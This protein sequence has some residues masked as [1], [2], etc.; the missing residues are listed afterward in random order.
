M[1]VFRIT[2]YVDIDTGKREAT[3]DDAVYVTKT[4]LEELVEI[5][6]LD[7]VV[8]TDYRVDQAEDI[9]TPSLL[10]MGSFDA[11]GSPVEK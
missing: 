9:E 10:E 3:M 2:A 6:L 5:K 1:T 8:M 11:N 7:N 4:A